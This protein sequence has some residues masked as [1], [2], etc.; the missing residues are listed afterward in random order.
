[1]YIVENVK[2]GDKVTNK[3]VRAIRPGGG[4]P[5]KMLEEFK[6]MKFLAD[7][8]KGTPMALDLVEKNL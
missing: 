2:A 8:L 7:F 4:C 3:N 1:L 6:G 5:P